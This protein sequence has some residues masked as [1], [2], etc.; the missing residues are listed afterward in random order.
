MSG[1]GVKARALALP[2]EVLVNGRFNQ[3]NAFSY[4]SARE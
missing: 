2:E 4:E 1:A 3:A